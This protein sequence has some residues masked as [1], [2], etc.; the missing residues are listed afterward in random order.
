MTIKTALAA[1][2]FALLAAPAIA[3]EKQVGAMSFTFDA[4]H[5]ERLV[6]SVIFYPA[7]KGGLQEWLGDNVVFKGE[8][9]RRDAKPERG[10]H[11]LVVVSH[12]SGGNAAGLAWLATRLAAQG[13]VVAIPN[14]Q[15]S[16]SADSTPE[17]TIPAMWERPADISRLLDEIAAS[18]SVSALVDENDISALGFSLGGA[19]ALKMVG[20]R[21]HASALAAFCDETPDAI[22]CPW[23]AKGNALIPG[24]V[25]LHK[26]DAERFDAAYP[27]ARI[28]RIVAI[29]PGFAPAVDMSSLSAVTADVQIINL[30]GADKL[31]TGV[32]AAQISKAIAH[33]RYDTVVGADHFDFLPECKTL[34]WFY[35]WLEGD[36][37]VC[38]QS[39]GASRAAIHE[40]AAQ[41]ILSFLKPGQAGK[42]GTGL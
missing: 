37:P 28:K 15:G 19:V 9:V 41:K 34:G 4:A 22:G 26:I 13:F 36:D 7:D 14:H 20:V 25:D 39:S 12:G 38:S 23:L 1:A 35:I 16:T 33:S 31:P 5:R 21:F 29:D 6:Q 24:H 8:R 27:D 2:A 11:P 10:K 17:T 3:Q 40:A 42:E 30:G 18:P 32:N